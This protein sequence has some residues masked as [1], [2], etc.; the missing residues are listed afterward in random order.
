R[1]LGYDVAL[2]ELADGSTANELRHALSEWFSDDRR[3]DEDLVVFYYAGHGYFSPGREHYLCT[4]DFDSRQPLTKGLG[5]GMV[6]RLIFEGEGR[7][8]PAVWILLDTCYSGLG[9]QN[10]AQ[11]LAD[12]LARSVTSGVRCGFL[13]ASR[14]KD[15]AEEG[16]FAPA[17]VE[18]VDELLRN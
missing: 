12:Y 15:E 16:A 7:K 3:K 8:K 18:T 5:T 6:P 4:K 13:A 14:P 1:E 11:Q 2:A 17:L 9:V 10:A